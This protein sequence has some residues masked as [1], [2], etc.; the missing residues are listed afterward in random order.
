LAVKKIHTME[1]TS[2]KV[3]EPQDEVAVGIKAERL[4]DMRKNVKTRLKGYSDGYTGRTVTEE[5]VKE[6]TS[7]EEAAI[8]G[9]QMGR[10]VEAMNGS[11]P[12]NALLG[13]IK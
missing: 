12:L 3:Y 4:I 2:M 7:I 8:L 11:N 1:K 10:E 9:F 5:V 6:A 13:M